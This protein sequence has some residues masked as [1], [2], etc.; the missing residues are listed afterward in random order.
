ME[1]IAFVRFWPFGNL[2]WFRILSSGKVHA[3][4]VSVAGF[5][6]LR[7]DCHKLYSSCDRMHAHTY[8]ALVYFVIH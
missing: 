2:S 8:Q 6:H 4:N 5:I 3:G 7:Y 1:A